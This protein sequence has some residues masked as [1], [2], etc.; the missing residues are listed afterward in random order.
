MDRK[1]F[2]TP[3]KF[4]C[5]IMQV[6]FSVSAILYGSAIVI[7]KKHSGSVPGPQWWVDIVGFIV[8]WM[9]IP[10][11]LWVGL[12]PLLKWVNASMCPKY[13]ELLIR[14]MLDGFYKKVKPDQAHDGNFRVTL[15]KYRK[16]SWRKLIDFEN[17][18]GEWLCPYERTGFQKRGSK[19]RWKVCSDRPSE[20]EGIAGKCFSQNNAIHIEELP[21]GSEFSIAG[22][23][24]K[25]KKYARITY[26]N[27]SY[28]DKRMISEPNYEWPR[29]FW[30]IRVWAGGKPWG[31]LLIDS[32]LPNIGD[33]L[34]L[35]ES[36]TE[37]I[38]FLD[39]ILAVN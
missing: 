31:V 21:S 7:F 8:D 2:R 29:S 10:V 4:V 18:F 13:K 24:D 32:T 14:K 16:F 19:Q 38:N 1:T 15:F 37:P 3:I 22:A 35:L 6:L 27:K 20:N 9:W 33:K 17:P 39:Q 12:N 30:G 23:R 11:V 5:L 28:I 36:A 26:V 34:D 25:K